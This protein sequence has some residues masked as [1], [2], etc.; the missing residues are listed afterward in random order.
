[1]GEAPERMRANSVWCSH[2][3]RDSACSH[4]KSGK[5]HDAQGVR[6]STHK[7]LA[8][9]VGIASPRLNA[10]LVSLDNCEKR[11]PEGANVSKS[12][13]CTPERS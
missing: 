11:E 5:P 3:A 6:E 7:R 13:N 8:S 12:L 4:S 10:A 2:K 9:V 1:M